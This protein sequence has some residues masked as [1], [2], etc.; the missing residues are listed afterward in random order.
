MEVYQ[1]L[2]EKKKQIPVELYESL[3]QLVAYYN[4]QPAVEEGEDARGIINDSPPWIAGGFVETEYSEGGEASPAE[5]M[6]MLLGQGKHGGRVWHTFNECK[7]NKDHIPVEAYNVVITRIS[8]DK[9]LQNAVDQIKDLL[10]EMKSSGIAPN[11]ETL[12]SVL[13]VLEG[14]SKTKDYDAACRRALDFMAEFRILEVEFSLGVYKKLLDLFVPIG[15]SRNNSTILIAIM[16]ELEGK[17]LYPARHDQDLWFFPT[18]M[19][20]CN[21]QNNAKLAWKVDDFLNS[22]LHGLLL[23]DF[24]M[25]QIYYT[26]FLSVIVQNDDFDTAMTLYNKMVPHTT[27]PMYNFYQIMLNH[28][29][30]SGALQYLGKVWDD[31]VLSDY[32]S[33]SAE[34]QYKLTSQVMQVL[35]SN[36]P[37]QHDLTGLK[38]V[39][40]DIATKVFNHLVE[41]KNNRRLYLRF[42]NS[43]APICTDCVLVA[44]RE[45]NFELAAKVVK[46]CVEEKNVMPSS[47]SEEALQSFA[48]ACVDL[49]EKEKVM[50]TVEYA[51]DISAKSALQLGLMVTKELEL[52]TEQKDY[53]NKLFA[54]HTE[55]VNI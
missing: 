12:I 11:N 44:L 26:N 13:T 19:K 27:T 39:W 52:D 28:L 7:A 50:E 14:F 8:Q 21:V 22:G 49:E 10:Q 5:R 42:N 1:L 20:V 53:L 29:H 25:E 2:K 33:A 15:K 23:S 41:G 36:D 43:A 40:I 9:G 32:G 17:Q 55:W 37:A 54:S 47:V 3:L 46:F 31:V 45:G 6:A 34:N 18:A 30:S 35:K 48:R 4:E 24:L 16:D 38:E 51:V